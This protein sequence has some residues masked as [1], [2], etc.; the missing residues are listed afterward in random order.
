M[1]YCDERYVLCTGIVHGFLKE[2]INCHDS[3]ISKPISNK[4]RET[5]PWRLRSIPNRVRTNLKDL[6]YS[7]IPEIQKLQGSC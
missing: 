5:T 7:S 6:K 1:F 2:T 3:R 4:N